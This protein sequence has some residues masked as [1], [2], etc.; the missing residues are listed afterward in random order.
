LAD[1]ILRVQRSFIDNTSKIT[2]FTHH[3]VEIGE[4]EI[5]IGSSYKKGEFG[6]SEDQIQQV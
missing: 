2:A 5:P 3:D 4:K 1:L 6:D